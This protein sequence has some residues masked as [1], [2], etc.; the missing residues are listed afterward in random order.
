MAKPPC[1]RVRKQSKVDFCLCLRVGIAD[2]F[3][4][5]SYLWFSAI[6]VL[7]SFLVGVVVSFAFGKYKN[8]HGS[9][10]F[11]KS[12]FNPFSLFTVD[13]FPL[14]R[15]P[16]ITEF[17]VISNF[18]PAPGRGLVLMYHCN[19]TLD[20]LNPPGIVNHFFWSLVG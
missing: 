11:F 10:C 16:D 15:S 2:D 3:Y 19:F 12:F 1:Q 8:K 20:I 7:T 4:H 6:S 9:G 18:S 14:C 13:R 17:P 5:I